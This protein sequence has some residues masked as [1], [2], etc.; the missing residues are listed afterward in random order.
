MKSFFPRELR[1]YA[2][3]AEILLWENIRAKKCSGLKFRRQEPIGNYIIDFVCF[4]P[5][6]VIEL[7]G[8]HH[9]EKDQKERDQNR[10]EWLKQE[11]FEILRFWNREVLK[12][13]SVVLKKIAGSAFP[14]PPAPLP[15]GER[16]EIR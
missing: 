1:K 7:D 8:N 2:T 13:V 6:I 12:D 11:G 3:E 15:Q 16:G 4:H 10:D 14:S 9:S 5:R